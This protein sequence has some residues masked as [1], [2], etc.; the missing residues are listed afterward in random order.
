M[1]TQKHGGIMVSQWRVG[2][3]MHRLARRVASG[4]YRRQLT[5]RFPTDAIR[6]RYLTLPPTPPDYAIR[7]PRDLS[8]CAAWAEL[9]NRDGEFGTWNA[10]RVER[11][12]LSRLVSPDAATLVFYRDRI[13]GCASTADI[14]T[15][16]RKIGLGMFLYVDRSHRVTGIAEIM[17]FRT[18]FFFV[19][20]GYDHIVAKTDP[21]RR[22]AIALYF[23]AGAR[24]VYD[25]L[26]SVVQWGRIIKQL[27]PVIRRQRERRSRRT[28]PR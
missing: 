24:P 11:E 12:L 19:E 23:G 1:L 17:T 10:E 27:Q 16:R 4:I 21:W 14:S 18:L 9:L 6:A 20:A 22:S 7:S 5:M 8:D 2:P 28:H 25:S 26:C 13:V 3:L 15:P